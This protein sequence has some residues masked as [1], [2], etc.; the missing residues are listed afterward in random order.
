MITSQLEDHFKTIEQFNR[1]N[2]AEAGLCVED[3]VNLN[4]TRLNNLKVW[5]NLF[6]KM[7]T[8]EETLVP[9]DKMHELGL[10]LRDSFGFAINNRLYDEATRVFS[11][12]NLQE[13]LLN[14][15]N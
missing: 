2:A 6:T 15:Q 8:T 11:L 9:K 4:H 7:V 14:R 10:L 3:Y 12:L 13:E 5:E 1:T